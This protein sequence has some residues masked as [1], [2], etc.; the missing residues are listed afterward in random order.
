MTDSRKLNPKPG[1][2]LGKRIKNPK[3]TPKRGRVEQT[4]QRSRFDGGLAEW[5][6]ELLGIGGYR[7][8]R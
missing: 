3:K 2:H 6:K 8:R 4:P 1:Q 7:S 5:E